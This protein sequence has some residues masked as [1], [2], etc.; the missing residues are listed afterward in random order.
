MG[1]KK[2]GKRM[3]ATVERDRTPSESLKQSLK[4]MKLMK[5]KKIPKKSWRDYIEEQK[6][7]N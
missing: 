2:G 7:E 3:H 4:E 6:R 5:E 1:K